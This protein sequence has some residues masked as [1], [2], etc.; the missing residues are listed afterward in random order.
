MGKVGKLADARTVLATNTSSLLPSLFA[1]STGA[2]ERFVAIHYANRI[3]SQNL[4]E[5]M[6]TP[7]TDSA[8][9]DKAVAFAEETGMVPVRV[10]KK[11]RG[12][13]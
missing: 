7:K 1:D 6:G 4:A 13:S 3:W 5:V 11:R 2:P 12:T 10:E 8:I 9:V